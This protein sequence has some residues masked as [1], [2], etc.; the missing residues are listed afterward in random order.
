[1]DQVSI[2][3]FSNG[4]HL[5]E[6]CFEFRELGLCTLN[7]NNHTL[8]K[9]NCSKELTAYSPLIQASVESETAFVH[10]LT[11]EYG[12]PLYRKQTQVMRDLVSWYELYK[13]PQKPAVGLFG[14]NDQVRLFNDAQD[15][16]H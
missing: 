6:N 5:N 11:Y 13:S 10:G 4:F 16:V 2:V 8:L 15:S 14:D 3:A 7:G 12:N 1:M 9:Y